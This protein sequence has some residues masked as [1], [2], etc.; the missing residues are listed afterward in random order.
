MQSD[1]QAPL[2][3]LPKRVRE[4][5]ELMETF[6]FSKTLKGF[7]SGLDDAAIGDKLEYLKDKMT[8]TEIE[9]LNKVLESNNDF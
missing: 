9:I 7:Y 6:K 1:K 3:T 4:Y 8:E 2:S 5:L